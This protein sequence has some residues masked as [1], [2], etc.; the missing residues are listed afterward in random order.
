MIHIES[1]IRDLMWGCIDAETFFKINN[2]A[3]IKLLKKG[4]YI[5]N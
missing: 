4:K 5:Q 3:F 2:P 1:Y